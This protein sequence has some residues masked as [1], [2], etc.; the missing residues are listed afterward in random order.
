MWQRRLTE[1]F[2]THSFSIGVR[3]EKTWV[4]SS[5]TCGE[6]WS[7]TRQSLWRFVLQTP[8]TAEHIRSPLKTLNL[9]NCDASRW[10]Y[11]NSLIWFPPQQVRKKNVLKD[12]VAVAG[13]LGVTHF[14]IFSKTTT[15]INMVRSHQTKKTFVIFCLPVP[16][17]ILW[18]VFFFFFFPKRLARLP[19]GP[20]LTFKVLKVSPPWS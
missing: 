11:L 12:F 20:T 14:M 2:P 16:L 6:S 4:S 13:P 19:K 18:H 7:H 3:S 10:L 17:L 5:W 1:P 9:L 15:N 8:L